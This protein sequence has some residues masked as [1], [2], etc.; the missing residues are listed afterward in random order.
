MRKDLD[1]ERQKSAAKDEE[2]AELRKSNEDILKKLN[3]LE[4]ATSFSE[5]N[6]VKYMG[7]AKSFWT[8]IAKA[9]LH[10]PNFQVIN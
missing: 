8:F 5:Q 6:F 3:D 4:K 7:H 2:L 1:A 9:G 10:A